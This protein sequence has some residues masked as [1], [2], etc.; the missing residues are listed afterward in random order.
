MQG[1]ETK[2]QREI[3][4]ERERGVEFRIK[5]KR[6]LKEKGG[7]IEGETKLRVGGR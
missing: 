1:G 7:K 5:E 3:G 4:I 6:K 2:K